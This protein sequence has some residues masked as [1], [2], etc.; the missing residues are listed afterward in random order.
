MGRKSITTKIKP[1]IIGLICL[2]SFYSFEFIIDFSNEYYFTL[3]DH[4]RAKRDKSKILEKLKNQAI[5][6][7]VFEE[8]LN[9]KRTADAAWEKH[10]EIKYKEELFGFKSLHFFWERFSLF[11]G[12]FIYTLY[13]LSL[14]FRY[15][16]KNLGSKI[17]HG[18][19]LSVC[20]FYFFWIFQKFQD[21]N[22][23]T[24]YLMTFVSATV[25]V[26][27][28]SLIAKYQHHHINSLKETIAKVA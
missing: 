27:A 25:I 15:E 12:V 24:Y 2:I 16:R 20:I 18:L 4:K 21:F 22:K 10:N 13:N 9:R 3:G 11:F 17:V 14:S 6:S 8:Y 7:T 1:Y 28:V 26:L 23:F 5:G 19:I